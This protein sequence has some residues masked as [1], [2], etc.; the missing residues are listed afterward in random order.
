MFK[1]LKVHK[2]KITIG[3]VKDGLHSIAREDVVRVLVE[4]EQSE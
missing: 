3:D 1:Y 2:P 4:Y